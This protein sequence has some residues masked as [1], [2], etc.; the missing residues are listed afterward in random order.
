[1]L[2]RD[3]ISKIIEQMVNAVARLIK[4]DIENDQEKF[5]EN[6]EEFLSTY[7]QISDKNLTKLLEENE[8]R[9][10]FLLDEKLKNQLMLL[11]VQAG[12]VFQK[13]NQTEK[14]KS[15]VKIIERIQNQHSDIYEFPSEESEKLGE[16]MEKL[17]SLLS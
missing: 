2:R 14:A 6:F 4:I 10:A 9:D 3:F 15:C 17:K 7:F 1:M 8:E 13:S 11:F 16:K 12:I 5:L